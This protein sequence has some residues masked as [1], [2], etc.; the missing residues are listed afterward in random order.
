MPSAVNSVLVQM[1]QAAVN[2][3]QALPYF[4]AIP[5]LYERQKNVRVEL[6]KQLNTLKG[7]AITILT[8]SGRCDSP[9]APGPHLSS[10][11]L[12]ASVTEN[13][14]INESAKGTRIP[15]S[16]AAEQVAVA[17]HHLVWAS[18]KTL[19]FRDLR[20]VPDDDYLVYNAVFETSATL[21]AITAGQ[22]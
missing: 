8:P 2:R 21:A 14:L 7:L 19:V 22:E 17:L 3:L 12:T 4:A 6:E 18:G 11:M 5:V 15:A 1:Q 16:E 20:L 10:V 13:V 9:A